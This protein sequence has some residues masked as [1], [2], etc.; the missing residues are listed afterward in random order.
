[1]ILFVLRDLFS[2]L[3]LEEGYIALAFDPMYVYTML[4]SVICACE[5]Q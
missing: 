1:M 5:V 2:H 4:Q 3:S